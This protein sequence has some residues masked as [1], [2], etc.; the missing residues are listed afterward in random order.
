MKKKV[1]GI[2]AVT[3]IISLA[4]CASSNYFKVMKKPE[5]KFYNGD[6]KG[7]AEIL[8]PLAKKKDKDQ[9]LYM[10]EAGLMF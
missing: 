4:S 5:K 2:F 3:I 8:K 10:M 1:W 6:F 9:L 7:A